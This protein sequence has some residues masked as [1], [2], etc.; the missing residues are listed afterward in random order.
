M[1]NIISKNMPKKGIIFSSLVLIASLIVF[2]YK[3]TTTVK[4][5]AETHVVISEVQIAGD[6]TNPS[7]D[8]FVELYNPKDVDVDLSGWRLT[9]MSSTGV[10]TGNFVSNMSGTIRSHCYF[11]I[12]HPNYDGS[13][14]YDLR[15]SATSSSYLISENNTVVLYSDAGMT[16]VDKV[17]LGTASNKETQTVSNPP[18][19]GS[20][21]RKAKSTS[22]ELSMSSGG[23][24]EF[25]GN[26]E[27]TDNNASDFIVRTLSDPQNSQSPCEPP[28]ASSTPSP[29][30]T[31]IPTEEPTQTPEPTAEPTETPTPTIEPTLEPSPTIEVT[32]TQEPSPTIELSPTPTPTIEPTETPMPTETPEPTSEITPTIEPSPTQIPIPTLEPTPAAH[33]IGKF[34]FPRKIVECSLIFKIKELKFFK[35]FFPTVRCKNY[36][37]EF[38]STNYYIFRSAWSKN[39]LK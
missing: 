39:R 26:G 12:A 18:D 35:I 38:N 10:T 13:V 2:S 9:R 28:E 4:S 30:E 21:E 11:L 3:R 31:P 19:N 36:N 25:L 34:Y 8:E 7:N 37:S 14:P 22:T 6:G 33:I 29:T 23:E 32:P 1:N 24:D 5:A 15:Y 17:G 16:T 27:D 20:V